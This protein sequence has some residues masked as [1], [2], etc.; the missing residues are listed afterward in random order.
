M[1][2]FENDSFYFQIVSFLYGAFLI[3]IFIVKLL[4]QSNIFTRLEII[5]LNKKFI[6]Q[7]L[8]ES[9]WQH[10]ENKTSDVEE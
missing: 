10:N 2:H 7:S 3:Y 1:S 4:V 8:E 5:F 9:P 6:G